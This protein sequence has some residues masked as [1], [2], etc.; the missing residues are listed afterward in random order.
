MDTMIRIEAY[1]NK[2]SLFKKANKKVILG[3]IACYMVVS[4][5]GRWEFNHLWSKAYTTQMNLITLSGKLLLAG[6]VSGFVYGLNID[7]NSA[8]KDAN[9]IIAIELHK[10]GVNEIAI[11]E[12]LKLFYSIGGDKRLKVTEIES[13]KIHWESEVSS[14]KL[15][16]M[17]LDD[18]SK[19][20]FVLNNMGEFWM[21]SV[22][23]KVPALID[24]FSLGVQENFA[25][26]LLDINQQYLLSCT[27][28]NKLLD[29]T[30]G[31]IK[32][33][34]VSSPG[35]EMLIKEV[36]SFNGPKNP[37]CVTW[38][39]SEAETI[40]GYEGGKVFVWDTRFSRISCMVLLIV[41]AVF[42][43]YDKSIT[44]VQWGHD[45]QLLYTTGSDNIPLH[46]GNVD[47][48]FKA[49]KLP[50]MWHRVIFQGGDK[51][52]P[53]EGEGKKKVKHEESAEEPEDDL[54]GWDK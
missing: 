41:L 34:N 43:P 49:W 24:K 27:P 10:D 31:T 25:D 54:L 9:E 32:I 29:S 50:S 8:K 17:K 51:I 13:Q 18:K 1:I 11:N 38:R 42:T 2:L 46:K 5:E 15:T 36:V 28:F 21:Y 22:A 44:K 33:I 16:C 6:T 7:F 48:S 4:K 23:E 39:A 3:N 12:E 52:L 26:V 53:S 37:C 45:M 47:N 35:K 14:T 20:L 30:A 40:V 19:R